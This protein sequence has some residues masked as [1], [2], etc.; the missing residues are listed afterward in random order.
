M[1]T[2][3]QFGCIGTMLLGMVGSL[4]GGTLASLMSGDGW[5]VSR[6]GFIGSVVGAALVLV[7]IRLASD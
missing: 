7:S 4:V 2:G 1:P 6:S 3:K 5:D